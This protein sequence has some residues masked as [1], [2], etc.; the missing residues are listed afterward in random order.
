MRIKKSEAIWLLSF[1]D[2]S[3]VLMSFFVLMLS[4]SKIDKSKVE[5]VQDGVAAK[6]PPSITVDKKDAALKGEH[7]LKTLST[8][9]ASIV[10]KLNMRKDVAINYNADGL[11]V[12]FKD[13]LLF[14]SG[15]AKSHPQFTRSVESV[16]TLIANTP[17]KYKLT[18]EGHTDDMPISSG[19][20]RSNWELSA[21]RGFTLLDMLKRKGI[22][23]ERMSVVSYAHTQPKV[24]FQGL[25][26]PRLDQ[27]RAA[28]RRVVI[29]IN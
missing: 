26:G 3:F 16:M 7:N 12:E 11:S 4:W 25:K 6:T 2:L 22:K 14:P 28:N 9:L 27:A 19:P 15:S 21:A 23:E 29:R 18:V 10:E 13:Q 1:C 17:K 20:F 5:N 24:P 8:E